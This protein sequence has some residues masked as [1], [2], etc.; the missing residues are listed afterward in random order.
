VRYDFE[1]GEYVITATTRV[2]TVLQ[3]SLYAPN[4]KL[5][6]TTLLPSMPPDGDPPPAALDPA[7]V[8]GELVDA[9]LADL[10]LPPEEPNRHLNRETYLLSMKPDLTIFEPEP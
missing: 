1:G 10:E 2:S 8:A 9:Y 7:V 5:V 4:E 3:Y 6:L